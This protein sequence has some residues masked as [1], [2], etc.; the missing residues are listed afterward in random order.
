MA[1]SAV[2]ARCMPLERSRT[3]GACEMLKI[4]AMMIMARDGANSAVS[5]THASCNWY[6]EV[7]RPSY[8]TAYSSNQLLFKAGRGGCKRFLRLGLYGP[9]RPI[10]VT[11]L[12]P[13]MFTMGWLL[14]TQV[15]SKWYLYIYVYITSYYSE[16]IGADTVTWSVCKS[17]LLTSISANADG[18]HNAV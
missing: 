17:Q 16:I 6:Q 1:D 8:H 10:I 4:L 15:M 9:Y 2:N 14:G 13:P 12:I 5:P 3:L 7:V 11:T 18:P